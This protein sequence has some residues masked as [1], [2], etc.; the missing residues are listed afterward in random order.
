[1]L[2]L[3]RRTCSKRRFA[4]AQDANDGR[5]DRD[6][7]DHDDDVVDFLADVGDGAAEEIAAE[8]C[9]GDPGDAADDVEHHVTRIRHFRGA[10]DRWAEGADD[11][12]EAGEDDGA[13]AVL[14]VELM[15][16]LKMA[17]AEEE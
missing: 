5:E 17:A 11:G 7:S 12:D 15:S 1:M 4:A 6:D 13:A 10:G 9:G 8:N 14:F 16:A 3:W 2:S